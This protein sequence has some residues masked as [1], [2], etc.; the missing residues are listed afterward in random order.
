MS[1]LT[2]IFLWLLIINLGL[3]LGAGIYESRVV[4]PRWIA[5]PRGEWADAGRQFWLYVTTGP[6]TL[7]TLVNLAA[8]WRDG[9]P[10]RT[11]WLAAA[12]IVLVERVAT[13]AYFIPTLLHLESAP[14][15]S[16]QQI[17][18][19]LLRWAFFNYGRHAL[20]L[21]GWLCALYAL[22]LAGEAATRRRRFG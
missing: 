7:L 22:T 19:G 12:V 4:I 2:I 17:A 10:R 1:R 16:P 13:F 18:N 15:L 3:A 9:P 14:G 11:W 5:M 6:L 8:A 20:L 21:A